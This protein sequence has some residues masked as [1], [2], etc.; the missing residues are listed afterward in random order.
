MAFFWRKQQNIESMIEIYQEHL[1]EAVRIFREVI[2]GLFDKGYGEEFQAGVLEVS[3]CES[4]IDDLRREIEMT[5]Y[6]RQLLPES[7][8]DL[9]GILEAVDRIPNMLETVLFILLDQEV[10]ILEYLKP[11]LRELVELNVQ[12]YHLVRKALDALFNNPSKALYVCK[13]VDFKESESDRLERKLIRRIYQSDEELAYKSQLKDVVLTIGSIS[14]RGE[15]CAD[16]I[17]IIAIKR[18]I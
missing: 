11:E 18:N 14:D 17:S 2:L 10:A 13:E 7:R 9:L 3:E 8:G 1:D 15:N 5:L 16:R 6:G 4:N 12:S